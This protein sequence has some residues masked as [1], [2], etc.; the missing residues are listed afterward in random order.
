[1]EGEVLKALHVLETELRVT[2]EHTSKARENIERLRAELA[3]IEEAT[4]ADQAAATEARAATALQDK[5]SRQSSAFASSL[6]SLLLE[7]EAAAAQSLKELKTQLE[8]SLGLAAASVS[9]PLLAFEPMFVFVIFDFF[10]APTPY[11]PS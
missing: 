7:S 1:M 6:T 11:A 3:G 10:S 4:A 5:Q 9:S 8:Q 2:K